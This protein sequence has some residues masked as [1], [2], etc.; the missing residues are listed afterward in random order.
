MAATTTCMPRERAASSTSSG[1]LPLPAMSPILCDESDMREPR[2]L[3]YLIMPRCDDLTKRSN[4]STS[5][6]CAPSDRSCSN[7]CDV[8]SFEASKTRSEE[9]TSELQSLRHLVCRLLLEK[10]NMDFLVH[11]CFDAPARPSRPCDLLSVV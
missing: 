2:L 4:A 8:F 10:K 9:H 7:A 6:P 11:G 3:S 1:N 5:S